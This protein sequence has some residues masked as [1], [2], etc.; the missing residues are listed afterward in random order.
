MLSMNEY[1]S[2]DVF[3]L[4]HLQ[5][6]LSTI[7]KEGLI[8]LP[9]HYNSIVQGLIYS[10]VRDEMPQ[11]HDDGFKA[12]GRTFRFFTF[13]RLFGKIEYLKGGQI[14]F[15]SPINFRVASPLEQFIAIMAKNLLNSEFLMLG[16]NRVY[17]KSLSVLP[18]PDF[19]SGKVKV[20]ALSPI[21]AYSTLFTPD[22][23]KKTYYYHPREEEFTDIIE[24]NLMKKAVYFN[25]KLGELPFSM[26]ILKVN[27]RDAKIIYYKNF[28]VKGWLGLYQLEGD[29]RLLQ[30]AYSAGLGSK[31]SQGFGMV[32][33]VEEKFEEK[34]ENDSRDESSK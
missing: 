23:K 19:S 22:G 14:A 21:T 6:E 7:D 1:K 34:S 25:E 8:G 26:H 2:E 11:L 24:A 18:L 30:L 15:R 33:V 28:V 32:N 10:M 13:S 5:I 16:N 12:L 17:L 31:N 20:K 3:Y 4:M 29:P 9:I 27:N